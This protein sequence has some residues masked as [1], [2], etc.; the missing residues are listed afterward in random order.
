M[1][2]SD[3]SR[4]SLLLKGGGAMVAGLSVLQ[5]AGPAHAFTGILPAGD[6]VA[7]G[8]D[9][10]DPVVPPGEVVPWDDGQPAPIPARG[11]ERHGQPVGLGGGRLVPHT[12]REV[13]LGQ[14]LRPAAESRC[15]AAGA[16]GS[17][18]WSTGP[19]SLS[20]ADLK[21]RP[22]R[23][24]DF[25]LECSGNSSAPFFIGGIGTA[26]WAG[27]QLAPLLRQAR[28][29]R[30]AS[31]VVFW[32]ADRGTVT[33]RDNAGITSAGRT[34]VAETDENGMLDLTITEQFARS[35]SVDEALSEDN[36]LCY[37]M[38]DEPLPELNG[39]P[40]RLIAPGWYGV[41]N[42]KWLTRIQVVDQ[43][44]TGKFMARDYV[45]IREGTGPSGETV[46][47]F[48]NVNHFRLKS[49]PAK[50]VRRAD[51]SH[52]VVGAAWGAPIAAVEVRI[53]DGPWTPAQLIGPNARQ[54]GRGSFAWTFW[55]FEWGSPASGTHGVTSRAFDA[56]G[57]LQPPPDDPFFASRRTYWEDNGQI[58]RRVTIA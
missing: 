48:A 42:V 55:A 40:L 15:R 13:L 57:N 4:R 50:V 39:F 58:T 12:Q 20:L 56:D 6:D 31:E 28:L 51:N 14:A 22:R 18:D 27:A 24:V 16:S 2:G 21:R 5:V 43:R 35:M 53:D 44:F 29:K 26:R 25:T 33:I 19:M 41:A 36:L 52:V 8:D 34:G 54:R 47:T 10:D 11:P 45:T 3:V 38:N 1:D 37:E 32:G 30:E 9:R 17:T 23:A 7:S 46:W 49:A